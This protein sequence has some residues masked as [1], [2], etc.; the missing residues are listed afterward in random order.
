[1]QSYNLYSCLF[2]RGHFYQFGE[3]RSVNVVPKQQCAFVTFTTRQA[4]EAAAEGSFQ[5]LI[6]KGRRL[7]IK[8][9]KPQSQQG[10]G[11]KKEDEGLKEIS[12]EPVPGLPGGTLP[13]FMYHNQWGDKTLYMYF[14]NVKCSGERKRMA[15]LT[16]YW[17]GQSSFCHA[18]V[19]LSFQTENWNFDRTKCSLLATSVYKKVILSKN[20]VTRFYHPTDACVS[21]AP[22]VWACVKKSK[23]QCQRKQVPK[24]PYLEIP[25]H[26][27]YCYS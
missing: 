19:A 3:L 17:M 4:T 7:N 1:M 5:K 18:T 16:L 15:A 2:L 9:G 27:V 11:G 22:R 20:W 10:S 8:W 26:V 24:Y 13:V 14:K 23:S 6:I 12:Y 21:S 25:A